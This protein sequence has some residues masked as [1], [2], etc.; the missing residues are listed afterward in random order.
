M[1]DLVTIGTLVYPGV[2]QLDLTGPYEV[3]SRLPNCR[4]HLLWKSPGP[5]EAA[6]G[7]LLT[8]TCTFQ[9]SPP[10]DVILVPGGPG[11][12]PLIADEEAIAFLKTMAPGCRYITSVCTGSLVLGAAGLLNGFRATSHWL[13]TDYLA[14][15]GATPVHERVVR[16]GNRIT[17][18]GVA[19]GLDFAL[20]LA[21]DLAGEKTAQLIQ[22][23]MEYDPAP[24]FSSG[25]P[26]TADPRLVADL[27]AKLA[28]ALEERRRQMEQHTG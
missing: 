24:P 17:G 19:A 13:W 28:D 9:D 12:T 15:F 22:L 11:Q 18:A 7:F 20:T 23:S 26:R 1:P 14:K 3:F 27:Q 10:L 6:S 4:Q 5:V 25:S 21:A 8:P 2:T 16:D